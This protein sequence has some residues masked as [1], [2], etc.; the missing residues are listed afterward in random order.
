MMYLCYLTTANRA[1]HS[2]RTTEHKGF[3]ICLSDGQKA[4]KLVEIGVWRTVLKSYLRKKM[5]EAKYLVQYPF[6]VIGRL[7]LA[8]IS[9][10]SNEAHL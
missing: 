9:E 10:R 8:F 3:R 6:E 4:K 5:I 2:I 7:T 1:N